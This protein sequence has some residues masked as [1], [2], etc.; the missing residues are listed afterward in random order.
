MALN[1]YDALGFALDRIFDVIERPR[2]LTFDELAE[3]KQRDEIRDYWNRLTYQRG[4]IGE[5]INEHALDA[6]IREAFETGDLL[7]LGVLVDR[8]VREYV[9]KLVESER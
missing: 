6:K 7:H 4:L 2:N 1:Q 8:A 5:A 9:G 3:Q